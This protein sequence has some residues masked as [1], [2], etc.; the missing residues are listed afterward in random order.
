MPS[1]STITQTGVKELRA[2]IEALPAEV[3]A[4]AR[5]VARTSANRVK[6][7]TQR[8]LLEQTR[9]EGNTAAALQV[10]EDLPNQQYRVTY[11]PIRNRPQNL[12][13]WLEYGTV[14]M[15]AR[16]H[17]RPS[18]EAAREPYAREMDAAVVTVARDLFED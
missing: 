13:F 7:D 3:T 1:H 15:H 6:L 11:G 8:R 18:A 14:R 12:P 2:A 17:M 9:G 4:T 10:I 16:P 5:R